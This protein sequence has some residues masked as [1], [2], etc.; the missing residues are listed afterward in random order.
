MKLEIKNKV[1]DFIEDNPNEALKLLR[2]FLS[3]DIEDKVFKL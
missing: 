1:Q 2:V 3:Q